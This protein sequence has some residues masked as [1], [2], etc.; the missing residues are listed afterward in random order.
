[1]VLLS[2]GLA[3]VLFGVSMIPQTGTVTATKVIVPIIVGGLLVLAFIPWALNPRNRH[4]LV[5]LRLFGNKEM[6][7]AV[8]TLSLFC[9]AFF[10]A[11]LLFPQYYQFVR[12]EDALHAGLL[13]A[14]QGIGAMVTMP[15]AG[16]LAD[17]I[18]P[19]KIVMTGITVIVV[20]MA[21]FSTLDESTPY[22]FLLLSLFIMGLG[23]G[24]TMMP[25]FAAAQATLRE[26]TIAR[27]STLVNIVQQVA[28]S[29]GTAIFTVL[30]TNGIKDHPT[31]AGA[32]VGTLQKVDPDNPD[33]ALL[34]TLEK[35]KPSALPDLAAVFGH[36]FLVATVMVAFC[37]VPAFFLPRSKSAHGDAAPTV[38][39]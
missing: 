38:L 23:M 4:P 2:P 1:M 18:G 21:M 33:P 15:I 7:V 29:I 37:L 16:T 9:I 32:Y 22:W 24:C 20:G 36:T 19:G 25:V 39:H 13:L 6:T 11:G 8:L 5:D 14:P 10:G 28:A 12:S 35:L 3:L 26:H 30:L 34:A 17:R 31:T 27:G